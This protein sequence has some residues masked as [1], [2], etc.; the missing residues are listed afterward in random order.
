MSLYRQPGQFASQMHLRLFRRGNP[1]PISDVLP[2]MENLGLKVISERPYE[3][4]S[5][6]GGLVW[7][8]DFELRASRPASRSISRPWTATSRMLAG[9]VWQGQ[10]END[11]FNR[12][13]L[14]ARTELASDHSAARLS[15]AISCRPA[16]PSARRTWN[17]C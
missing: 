2:M 4:E 1:I 14:A 9:S 7:I 6:A 17:R 12:L 10:A 5:P 11:G 3:V 13:V 8:Q 15:A 16:F